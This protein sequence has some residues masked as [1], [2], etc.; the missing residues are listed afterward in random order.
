MIEY[1]TFS[2]NLLNGVS[3]DIGF[4]EPMHRNELN[5]TYLKV[6]TQ[7]VMANVGHLRRR[8]LKI[9]KA[10]TGTFKGDGRL[11]SVIQIV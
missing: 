4:I 11:F 1:V 2:K 9:A 3:C 6:Y 5:M 8:S 10:D 7:W